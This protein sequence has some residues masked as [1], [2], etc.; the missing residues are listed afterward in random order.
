MAR[1]VLGTD[2]V[3][4]SLHP[5][6]GFFRTGL[7]DT[8]AE[9]S[10]MHTICARMTDHFLRFSRARGNDLITPMPAYAF[11]GLK[12]G[13]YWCL[14]LGRWLEA[15]EAG[16]APQVKLAA[17]HASVLEF[18]DLEVLREHADDSSVS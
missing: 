5:V 12:A 17:T 11:P 9:D 2:L 1:N 13:D 16:V 3:A 4:C 6:T 14:C 7:C 15:L 8:C 10:G 18:V